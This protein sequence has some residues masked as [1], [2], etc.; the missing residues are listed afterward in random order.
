MC[1]RYT[2]YSP[3]EALTRLFATPVPVPVQARYNIAPTQFAPVIRRS[4]D[5]AR[6]LS[7][8]HWGLVPGWARERSIGNRMINARAETLA[9][10]PSFRKA[11][12]R[13]RCL[14]LAS[15]FYE[16]R[17]EGASKQPWYI[18]RKDGEPMALAGLWEH[19]QAQDGP[20]ESFTIV[21]TTANAFMEGLHHRMPAMLEPEE[22][23]G[24][25]DSDSVGSTPALAL[26]RP[27]EGDRLRAWAVSTRVNN[28]RNESPGLVEPLAS[29][30]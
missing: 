8:L 5:G 20:L 22:C 15:G 4:A 16:W 19:W 24:W 27:Q 1:G 18:S 6:A 30:P 29:T 14:V 26:L 2:F 23:E 13:R 3:A 12:A 9:E 28:P 21:T 25:L 10:K 17:K 11:L 7:M